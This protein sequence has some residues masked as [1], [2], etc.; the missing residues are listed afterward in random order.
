MSKPVSCVNC[1]HLFQMASVP[2]AD[3][4]GTQYFCQASEPLDTNLPGEWLGF[5]PVQAEWCLLK[6]D[7]VSEL[8]AP[9]V[10]VKQ[11]EL[12]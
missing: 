4:R 6:R 11:K 1:P 3:F 10:P 9:L 7:V 5:L 12:F 8:S 2:Q